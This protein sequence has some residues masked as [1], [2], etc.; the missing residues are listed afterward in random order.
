MPEIPDRLPGEVILASYSNE[1]RDRAV[2]RYVDRST[3]DSENPTPAVG[4]LS[5]ITT[6][7]VFEIYDGALWRVYLDDQDLASIDSR[8][9]AL[10]E[11][12]DSYRSDFVDTV[13]SLGTTLSSIG[14]TVTIPT[15]GTYL[16]ALQ[17]TIEIQTAGQTTLGGV[18]V[19]FQENGVQWE[20]FSSFAVRHDDADNT[21]V[22]MEASIHLLSERAFTAGDTITVLAARSATFTQTGEIRQ[23]LL[24]ARR[25][26]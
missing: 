24:T 9:G 11:I 10:E 1:I 5:Y 16:I 17:S 22:L 7:G 4:E 19:S 15:S 25:V 2:M 3:R 12:R 13:T 6:L 20:A 21:P 8:L 23:K 14:T 26:G 18:T